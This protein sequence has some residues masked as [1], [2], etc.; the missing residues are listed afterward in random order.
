MFTTPPPSKANDVA[1]DQGS[2]AGL[3]MTWATSMDEDTVAAVLV[4]DE[5]PESAMVE[6]YFNLARRDIDM[7]KKE[8]LTE[9]LSEQC[10]FAR[11]V[12]TASDSKSEDQNAALGL[13]IR[14]PGVANAEGRFANEVML[15]LKGGSWEAT[16]IRSRAACTGML[17]DASLRRACKL[18]SRELAPHLLRFYGERIPALARRKLWSRVL[19]QNHLLNKLGELSDPM[20]N[21]LFDVASTS[22][23]N[24]KRLYRWL[25]TSQ[26]TYHLEVFLDLTLSRGVLNELEGDLAAILSRLTLLAA[27]RGVEASSE[28]LASLCA[29]DALDLSPERSA[30]D[31]SLVSPADVTPEHLGVVIG[32][33][34]QGLQAD[35]FLKTGGSIQRCEMLLGEMMSDAALSENV[36]LVTLLETLGSRALEIAGDV[37]LCPDDRPLETRVWRFLASAVRWAYRNERDELAEKLWRAMLRH[38]K[39]KATE[40]FSLELTSTSLTPRFLE[41]VLAK[42]TLRLN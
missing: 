25:S 39:K 17:S 15:N 5:A 18:T 10:L 7:P 19:L 42:E 30:P 31:V 33:A 26:G 38:C 12:A 3:W 29:V 37:S 35:D 36:A 4:S 34:I 20:A 21:E 41:R 32:H 28:M 11:L 16:E 2:Q 40:Q 13:L 1:I 27:K 8:R 22:A 23:T 24:L 6:A 14:W 9:R